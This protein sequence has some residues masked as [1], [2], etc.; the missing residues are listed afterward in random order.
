[1]SRKIQRQRALK[2]YRTITGW[3]HGLLYTLLLMNSSAPLVFAG[4]TGGQVVGGRGSINQTGSTP[5]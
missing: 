3:A 4:P 5:A 2:S 1:M